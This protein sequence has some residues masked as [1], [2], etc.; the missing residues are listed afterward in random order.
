MKKRIISTICLILCILMLPVTFISCGKN[1]VYTLGPYEI[2]EDEYTYLIG[3]YK[4]RLLATLGYEEM[5]MSTQITDDGLTIGQYLDSV[6]RK[7]FDI[8][9]Y[10][11]LL[12][13][14]LFDEYGLTLTDKQ[15]DDIEKLIDKTVNYYGGY[16]EQTFKRIVKQ[17]GYTVDTMR[18]VYTMQAKENAVVAHLYGDDYSKLTAEAKE[19]Y[20]ESA[21]LHFQVI[22]INNVYKAVTDSDGKTSYI[23]LSE[24]EKATK[25]QIISEL[26]SLLVKEDREAKYP[27]ITSALKMTVDELFEDP[28]KTYDLLFEKYSDDTLYPG[29]YYMIAPT[30]VNQI[31][32]SNALSAAFLLKEGDCAV[33]TAKRYFEK[34]GTIEISGETETINAGDYFEYGEAFVR[35]LPLDEGAY[36]REENKDFFNEDD[37][38]YMAMKNDFYTVLENYQK[39]CFYELRESSLKDSYSIASAIAN[40]LDYNFIYASKTTDE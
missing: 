11:L 36:S 40:D 32:T 24:S 35:K 23:N 13:Q 5:S 34:D 22:V 1:S 15:K 17:Y 19:N 9:I 18:S 29:G 16:S 10:T 6:Y 27:V 31:V 4:R 39:E 37:F 3:M 2:K 38:N 30:S 28:G 33:V 7:E 25:N 21:Y 12:S 20:Y 8:S 26:N 14:S